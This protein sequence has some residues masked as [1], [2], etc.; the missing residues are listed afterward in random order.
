LDYAKRVVAELARQPAALPTPDA[1][2]VM[3]RTN[4]ARIVA[5]KQ[6][7]WPFPFPGKPGKHAA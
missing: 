2:L 3:A 1:R 5:A 7:R 4:T 6:H